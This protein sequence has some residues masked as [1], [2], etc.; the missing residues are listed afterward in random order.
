MRKHVALAAS[1]LA[2]AAAGV[3]EAS[4]INFD[5]DGG[6]GPSYQVGSFDLAPGNSVALK[7]IPLPGAPTSVDQY[8]QARLGN[9]LDAN[10][11][12]IS[13]PG[14]NTSYEITVVVGVTTSGQ[15]VF[16]SPTNAIALFGLAP[17]YSVNYVEIWQDPTPDA[18]DLAGTGFR[19]GNL[20]MTAQVNSLSAVF[21]SQYT[22]IQPFDQFGADDYGIA[23]VTGGGNLSLS[24]N[25]LT[26]DSSYFIDN[27]AVVA[28]TANTANNIPFAQTN[29][30]GQ[31]EIGPVPGTF[32]T[33][34][35]GPVN[36]LPSLAGAVQDIQLQ[37][38][39][40]ASFTIPEPASLPLLLGM[41]ALGV[42]RRRH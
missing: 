40:S 30:S 16:A 12:P 22:Q 31:F 21:N 1:V 29:P 3:V 25:V 14:L 41:I 28:L 39:A 27:M 20:I 15:T 23:S 34:V 2:L 35:L 11:L 17:N 13:V 8:F 24:A 7:S 37:T 32:Y 19:D 38:D 6:G 42:R 5:P 33:P 9:L 10:S 4:I 18:N 36:G 26:R